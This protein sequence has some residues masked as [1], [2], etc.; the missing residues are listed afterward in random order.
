MEL[1]AVFRD[2]LDPDGGE[3][4]LAPAAAYPP[5]ATPLPARTTFAQLSAAAAERGAVALGLLDARD[6][7]QL[8][9]AKAAPLQVGPGDRL[10]LFADAL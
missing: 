8:A 10:V 4:V 3:L 7:L 6:R 9:P 2:L 1:Q 5:A